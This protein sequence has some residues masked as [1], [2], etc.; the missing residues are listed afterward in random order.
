MTCQPVDHEEADSDVGQCPYRVEGHP[1]DGTD[2]AYGCRDDPNP[3]C[4]LRPRRDPN[5][6]KNENGGND[7]VDPSVGLQAVPEN[8]ALEVRGKDAVEAE[9]PDGIEEPH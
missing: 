2:A 3:P 4:T 7:D 5:T 8:C 6:S 9:R 1:P